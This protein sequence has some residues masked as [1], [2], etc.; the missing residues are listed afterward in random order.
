MIFKTTL[1]VLLFFLQVMFIINPVSSEEKYIE[2]DTI[3]AIAETRTITKLELDNKK[4]KVKKSQN[5]H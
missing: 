5:K 3:V 2:I 4:E 1:I